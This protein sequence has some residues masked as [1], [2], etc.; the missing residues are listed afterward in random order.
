MQFI[1]QKLKRN[2][3]QIAV[4][5][6][7]DTPLE[8]V[9]ELIGHKHGTRT[10]ELAIALERLGYESPLHANPHAWKQALAAFWE[11]FGIAQV[12][13]A[14]RA[15]WHWVAIGKDANGHTAVYDGNRSGPMELGAYM[16]YIENV[17]GARITS[18][19]PVKKHVCQFVVKQWPGRVVD[20]CE[21]GAFRP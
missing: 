21:C 11:C 13:S 15:G 2:C 10:W 14:G 4:A 6:L 1:E 20:V 7:T 19:L 3:G 18:F 9:H 17:E 8:K 16:R 12:H 5:A